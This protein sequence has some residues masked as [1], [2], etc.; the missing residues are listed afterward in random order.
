MTN[1]KEL[2]SLFTHIV[3]ASDD[4]EVKQSKPCPDV[5]N[6]CA[7]RFPGI[8]PADKSNVSIVCAFESV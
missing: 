6:V 4:P 2:F 3:F 1:H 5:F 7:K 8:Q